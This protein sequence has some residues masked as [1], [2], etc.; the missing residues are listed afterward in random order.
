LVLAYAAA[1]VGVLAPQLATPR[2]I[3]RRRMTMFKHQRLAE[4]ANGF[5]TAGEA[6]LRML[7]A[8]LRC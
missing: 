4:T 5:S 3:Y 6:Q 7:T 2:A 8:Y 1:E